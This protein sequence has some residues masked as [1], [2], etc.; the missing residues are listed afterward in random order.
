MN[1]YGAISPAKLFFQIMQFYLRFLFVRARSRPA[2]EIFVKLQSVLRVG[3][4]RGLL[5]LLLEGATILKIMGESVKR[6]RLVP[7]HRT[8]LSSME[9]VLN[10]YICIGLGLCIYAAVSPLFLAYLYILRD[11]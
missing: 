10:M 8:A 1:Y 11:K 5:E 6:T 9:E 3:I 7:V 4:L 2:K